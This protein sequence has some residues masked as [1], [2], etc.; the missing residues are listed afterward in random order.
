MVLRDSVIGGRL[1][2]EWCQRKRG[3]WPRTSIGLMSVWVGSVG[4]LSTGVG[5]P[6]ELLWRAGNGTS[7]A[8]SAFGGREGLSGWLASPAASL[9]LSNLNEGGH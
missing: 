1:K 2:N 4:G 8:C 3:G 7:S 6:G 9:T 5:T